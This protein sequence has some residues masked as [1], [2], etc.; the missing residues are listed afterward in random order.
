MQAPGNSLRILAKHHY[1]P[2]PIYPHPQVANLANV[3]FAKSWQ[4]GAMPELAKRLPR[5]RNYP[6]K[7]GT[8]NFYLVSSQRFQRFASIFRSMNAQSTPMPLIDERE[9]AIDILGAGYEFHTIELGNDPDGETDV[10]TTVVRF[11]PAGANSADHEFFR[12][13]ALLWVHGMTDYFF[14][15]EFAEYFHNAGFA[16]YAVDLRK[17]GRS[18]RPG[19]QWHFATDLRFYFPD[20]NA[21]TELITAVHPS[22]IPAAHSTGGLIVPLWLSEL[23]DSNPLRHSKIS[24]LI[25][26]SPWLDL[27]YP[28]VVVRLLTP[29]IQ[30][31]GLKKP[32]ALLPNDGL[33]PY[34]RSIHKDHFGEWDFDTVLKPVE[35][36]KKNLGWLRAIL[37]GHHEVHRD[38]VN[39]G[40]DVLT[41]CSARSWFNREYSPATD[42]ADAVL[43]V[44][45]I[46]KWA[47]HLSS[48]ASRVTVIPI[49]D[50]R[51]DVFLSTQGVRRK[52]ME[53]VHNWLKDH[54]L[55]GGED[56]P[57]N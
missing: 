21:A 33:G 56:F 57:S 51:H 35:G 28:R 30:F 10:V 16:V 11:N 24:G 46:Q 3:I 38:R 17:C 36:H 7:T 26:N 15:T 45:Q 4:L 37:L 39:V 41:I 52:A 12:R 48:P 14:H 25:L 42:S 20:L 54:D 53:I 44:K 43:D 22:L 1:N 32:Q 13:P 55:T 29:V 18:H 5:K 31:L 19:Q 50:A 49:E 6:S 34:G 27:M 40:V 8:I 9:W 23:K 47:P 2:P